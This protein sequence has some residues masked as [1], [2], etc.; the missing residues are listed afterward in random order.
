M[1]NIIDSHCHIYPDAIARRA[2]KGIDSFYGGLPDDHYD[3]TVQTLL[4]SGK[5]SGVKRFVVHSVATKPEQVGSI[6]AFIAR[7][8]AEADGAFIGMGTLHP[9]S[10]DIEAD[11][12]HLRALGLMGVKLHPDFQR[13]HADDPKAM[14]LFELIEDAGLPVCV[15]T[16]DYRFDYSNPARVANVLRTFPRLKF[17]GAHFG[18]WSVWEDA[19]RLLTDFDNIVVDSSSTFRFIKPDF[20][21]A[22]VEAW[23]PQRVL[24]GTDYPMWRAQ[25][26]IEQL[27]QMEL[28]DTDYENIFWKN[29]A[30]LF[31]LAI[32]E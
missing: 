14:R 24:F 10:A 2:V 4:E 1:Y 17:I 18:G 28:S 29:T 26:D 13:F 16:G 3:G 19:L 27:L 22:L 9:D 8:M 23:T 21:K 11:F 31:G 30:K 12:E 20:A 32:D 5:Q 25:P 6:N 15:H 7:S